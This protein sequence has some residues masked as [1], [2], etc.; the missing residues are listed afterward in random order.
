MW[1]LD[2]SKKMTWKQREKEGDQQDHEKQDQAMGGSGGVLRA[3][4]KN[5]DAG[6]CH[7]QTHYFEC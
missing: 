7:N 4:N 3:N 6:L 2:F 1:I 5:T